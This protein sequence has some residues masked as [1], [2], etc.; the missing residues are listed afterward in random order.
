MTAFKTILTILIL[1]FVSAC[2]F[3]D[4]SQTGNN[5][6]GNAH[7]D[8]L[9][10]AGSLLRT[11]DTIS[12]WNYDCMTDTIYRVRD[13]K[14][15]KLSVNKMIN[16]INAKYNGKVSLDFVKIVNDTIFVKISDSEYLTQQMGTAG[17]DEYMITTTFT[18][19]ELDE[20]DFVKFDFEFGDHATPGTYSRQ[21]YW[22]WINKKKK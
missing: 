11:A 6:K 17:A 22:D 14:R 21:Y 20:I 5:K 8:T 10:H 9:V 19:T 7:L 13:L 12:I 2:N 1:V 16:I 4:N 3:R 15:D 18:L